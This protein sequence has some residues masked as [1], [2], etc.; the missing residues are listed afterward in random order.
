MSKLSLP[1]I[2][3]PEQNIDTL[4]SKGVS[5]VAFLD[6]VRPRK[7]KTFTVRLQVVYN[8]IPK[9]YSTNINL[10]EEQYLKIAENGVRGDLLEKK[11]II[12]ALLKKANDIICNMTEFSFDNFKKQLFKKKLTNTQDIFAVLKDE[13]EKLKANDQLSTAGIYKWTLDSL[14]TYTGKTKLNFSQ[15]TPEFLNGYQKWMLKKE[16]SKTTVSLYTRCIRKIFNSQIRAGSI[17][18]DLYPFGKGKYEI[19]KSQNIKKALSITDI[20]KIFKYEPMEG[21]PEHYYRDLWIFIY[22]CNGI[23]VKDICLLKYSNIKGDTIEYDRAKTARKNFKPISITILPETKQIIDR[24]GTKP[25]KPN[26]YIFPI[27]KKNMNPETQQKVI[28]QLTKQINKYIKRIAGKVGI[29]GNISSYTA[30]HSYATILMRS[31]TSIA[32]ISQALGH[33]NISTTENYLASFEEEQQKEI[34]KQL[35]NF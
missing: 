27:L 7:D 30:R 33:S 32:F 18:N 9:Y 1:R 20:A 29:V 34:A 19:P 8:R 17:N 6:T 25:I 21:T 4:R 16:Y 12:H 10:T 15:V 31:G 23:N 26:K 14:V 11:R 3:H 5:L 22:M 28:K 35:T 2:T 13:K 24:W